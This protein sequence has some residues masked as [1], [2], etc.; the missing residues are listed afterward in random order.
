MNTTTGRVDAQRVREFCLSLF[1]KLGFATEYAETV[2]DALVEAH[3]RGAPNQGLGRLPIYVKRIEQGSVNAKPSPRVV[4]ETESTAVMDGDNSLGHYAAAKAMHLAI[5]KAENTGI[6]AVGVM[7]S[8]HFGIAAYY[9]MLAAERGM[10]GIVMSNS[11][12]LMAAPGGAERIIGNNPIS[13]AV[14]FANHPPIVLDMACSNAAFS[15]IQLAA[16]QGVTVPTGWGT[17]ENGAETT[18]PKTILANGM[19]TPLGGYKGFGL[20]L[21]VEIL[22]G[23]LTGANCGKDVTILYKDLEKKQGTGHFVI[24]IDIRQFMDRSVFDSRLSNLVQSIKGSRKAEGTAEI[25]LPGEGSA[26]RRRKNLESGIA[27]PQAIRDQIAELAAAYGVRP[28][29]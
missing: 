16:Q 3:L 5:E 24:A 29:V 2:T 23:V 18:E 7:N 25:V 20:A 14:P 13:I 28:P 26:E 10:I 15:S 21:M 11:A 4:R 27:L 6:G 12:P 22:V 8:T 1:E 19:L 17:D 9:S